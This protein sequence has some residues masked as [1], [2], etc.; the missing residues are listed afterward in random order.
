MTVTILKVSQNALDTSPTV[1]TRWS[2]IRYEP[3]A[4]MSAGDRFAYLFR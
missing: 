1:G 2:T 3:S 4:P